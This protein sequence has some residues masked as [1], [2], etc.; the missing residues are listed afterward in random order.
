MN[1]QMLEGCYSIESGRV[2]SYAR[3]YFCG[4]IVYSA[5]FMVNDGLLRLLIFIW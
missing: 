2:A 5:V 3:A 4:E 1:L